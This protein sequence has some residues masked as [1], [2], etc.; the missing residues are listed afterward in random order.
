MPHL[1]PDSM[2]NDPTREPCERCLRTGTQGPDRDINRHP[3]TLHLQQV[4][5][6]A[7]TCQPH[8]LTAAMMP[9][10]VTL[11]APFNAHRLAANSP[12]GH[13]MRAG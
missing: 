2:L 5:C 10:T 8:C 13:R 1:T 12:V 6:P 9:C 11:M 4:L 3:G 7:T